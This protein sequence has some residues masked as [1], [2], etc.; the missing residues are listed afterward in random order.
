MK[1]FNKFTY[2]FM[3]SNAGYCVSSN[4]T[5][6]FYPTNYFND[7]PIDTNANVSGDVKSDDN[8]D[9]V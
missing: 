5:L 9:D 7:V 2:Y 3:C 1:L 4:N 8:S 6:H